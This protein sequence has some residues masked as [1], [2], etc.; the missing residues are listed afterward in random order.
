MNVEAELRRGHPQGSVDALNT[1]RGL[2][3]G[4]DSEGGLGIPSIPPPARGAG[5]P[6]VLIPHKTRLNHQL[7][8]EDEQFTS[9]VHFFLEDYRFEAVWSTPLKGISYVRRVGYAL[10]PDFSLY[11]DWPLALQ[12]FN[13]YRNRWCG[14]YWASEGVEV[15]PTVSWSDEASYPFCFMGVGRGSPV[16]ISTV[17]VR[18][19]DPEER[20]LFEEGCR[21]MLERIEPRAVL[22][23]AERLPRELLGGSGL[24]GVEVRLY[25]PRWKSIREAR[26]LAAGG[27]A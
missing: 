25:P 21:E 6:D 17:G 13:V 18:L 10:S 14:A 20:R 23:Q 3:L 7:S 5:L 12:L 8:L 22:V 26:K 9:A 15:I 19:S 27:R 11:R 24:D 2:G 1:A 16:A 4:F